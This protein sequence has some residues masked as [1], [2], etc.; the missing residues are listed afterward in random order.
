MAM[1]PKSRLV[2]FGSVKRTWWSSSASTWSFVVRPTIEK[3]NE[4]TAFTSKQRSRLSLTAFASI[5]V[6]SGNLIPLRMVKTI[7][8]LFLLHF[9]PD[10]TWPRN[11]VDCANRAPLRVPSSWNVAGI[12]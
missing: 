6:P 5:G 2:G 7:S 10:A 3:R 1:L 9:Q 11:F 4:P 8:F 12:A